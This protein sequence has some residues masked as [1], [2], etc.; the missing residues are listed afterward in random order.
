MDPARRNSDQHVTGLDATARDDR[1][2]VHESDAEAHE[3]EA[4]RRWMAAHHVGQHRKLAAGDLH[5]GLLGSRTQARADLFQHLGV[6]LLDGDVVEQ[7]N[8]VGADADHVVRV[9]AEQ[10]DPDRVVAP[11]LLADDHLRADAVARQREAALV[12]EPQDVRVVPARES[13][14]RRAP[15]PDAG[16][17]LN[18]RRDRVPGQQLVHAG[19]RVCP[20]GHEP[21]SSGTSGVKR[22]RAGASGGAAQGESHRVVRD[23]VGPPGHVLVHGAHEL[24]RRV[25]AGQPRHE[26]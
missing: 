3:V 26:L 15:C 17:H 1:V 2:Q 7:R 23:A 9:H 13:G 25:G 14:A 11:E 20:F 6:G 24:L 16:Q 22:R 19:A 5:A 12:V 21:H 4:A 10:V 18:Q 8:R